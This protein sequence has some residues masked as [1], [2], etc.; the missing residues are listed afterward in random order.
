[1]GG[2]MGSLSGVHAPQLG[3][4]AIKAALEQSNFP[5]D[6]IDE[7]LFGNVVSAGI[8]QAPARQAVLG[9]GL[10]ESI[11]CTTVNKVCGSGMKCVMIGS[12][13][14]KA[15]ANESVLVGG[16][17]NMSRIPY[18]LPDA[19]A[20]HR[21]GNKTA[22]DA[23]VHDGLWDPYGNVHMGSCG[24]LCA[25]EYK[26]T[27]E[28]QDDYT[29]QS[30]ENA[31]EAVANN[32]FDWEIAPVEVKGRG[33]KVTVVSHD[34]GPN[35][36]RPDK[37]KALRSAFAKEGTI[38]AANASSIND[39]ASALILASEEK[40]KA[41]GLA[42]IAWVTGYSQH[43]QIPKYFTT[44]PGPAVNKLLN[45]LSLTPNDIDLWEINEAFAVVTL[46]AMKDLSIPRDRVNVHGGATVLGHPIGSSG[47]RIIVTLLNALRAKEKKRGVATL[48]IGGGEATAI[49]VEMA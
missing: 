2:F 13:S 38:T 43:A 41:L 46:A 10:S 29:L 3:A 49:C 37:V 40:V 15:Q 30:I 27:R 25:E 23:M 20:G 35:L 8:G 48:C 44:A 36:V 6:Q 34:E 39:G 9:A 28:E 33:G 45:K 1:M 16:L 31:K 11:P 22:I 21:M 7:A 47:S 42:P 26:I 12:D 24:E 14:I 17:E 19:R 5:K 4:A 32:V 18:L